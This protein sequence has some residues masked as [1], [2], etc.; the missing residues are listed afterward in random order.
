MIAD[1]HNDTPNG[2]IALGSIANYMHSYASIVVHG[3][4]STVWMHGKIITQCKSSIRFMVCTCLK[5][6]QWAWRTGHSSSHFICV[7]AAD[8][9]TQIEFNL[10]LFLCFICV[11]TKIC[12]TKYGTGCTCSVTLLHTGLQCKI[13]CRFI[14]ATPVFQ[15]CFNSC[16][17]FGL[18]RGSGMCRRLWRTPYNLQKVSKV[19]PWARLYERNDDYVFEYVGQCSPHSHFYR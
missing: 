3:K 9:P 18:D 14:Y 2:W 8:R 10:F 16:P 13:V 11:S 5:E 12:W 19:K 1:E 15:C 17:L 6:Q 7:S 4:W